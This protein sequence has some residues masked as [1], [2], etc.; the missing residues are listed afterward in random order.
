MIYRVW[1]LILNSYDFVIFINIAPKNK[2]HGTVICPY[3]EHS[4]ISTLRVA[5]VD[6]FHYNNDNLTDLTTGS[7][8]VMSLF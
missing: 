2:N 7:K 4:S 5:A 6:M 3:A 8:P 1:H